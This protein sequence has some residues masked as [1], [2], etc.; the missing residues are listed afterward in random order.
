VAQAA[1]ADHL[2]DSDA[3]DLK[4][5]LKALCAAIGGVDVVY[6]P[7]GGD[8]FKA[9]LSVC[10]R[11]ARVLIIGFASGDVPQIPANLLLVKNITVIGFYW[12]GYLTFAPQ[13]L[14]DSLAE[15]MDWY[16]QGRLHPHVGA[17]LP[18]DRAGE[19]LAHLADRTATG[20]IVVTP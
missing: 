14:G 6:D 20:K 3:G 2:I 19:A 10:N 15:L 17:V 13:V 7:V 1:G 11:E 4:A 18:L 9:A 5:Q 16:A 8:A 12:G